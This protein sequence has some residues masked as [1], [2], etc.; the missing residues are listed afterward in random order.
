MRGGDFRPHEEILVVKRHLGDVEQSV[1]IEGAYMVYEAGTELGKL[2]EVTLKLTEASL[3]QRIARVGS[4]EGLKIGPERADLLLH[5]IVPDD[6]FV[7]C[8]DGVV[9]EWAGQEPAYFMGI[10]EVL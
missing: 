1:N 4:G 2:Y 8:L 5:F 6:N 9:V 7:K 10:E 3:C